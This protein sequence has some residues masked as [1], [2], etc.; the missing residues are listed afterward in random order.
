MNTVLWIAQGILAV[1]FLMVGMMKLTKSKEEMA[2]KMAWV[3]DFSQR[4]IRGIGVLEILGAMGLI[5]PILL[6]I[7]PILTPL[8]AIGLSLT[9]AGAFLTH[10]RR[11]EIVPMGVM[12][13]ILFGMALFVAF[14]RF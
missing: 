11:K 3:E 14:G 5:L 1:M 8:A 7:L 12:N 9:M 4:Q 13:I 2:E 10:L 6:G